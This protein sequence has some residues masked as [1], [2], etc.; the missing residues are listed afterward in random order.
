MSTP[1]KDAAA[2]R[3]AIALSRKGFPTPNPHVGCVI[4]GQDGS[5]V[6]DGWCD[7]AGAPHAEAMALDEAGTRA[8]GGTAYVTLEPCN[9]FGRTPPCSQA[10][11]RAGVRRVVIAALDP[12]PVA[13]GGA[14][15]LREAG[16]EV[17][18]GLLAESAAEVNHQ[19]LFAMAN[20]RP[21]FTLKAAVGLDGRIALPNGE[22]KWI[23]GPTARKAGHALRA[24]CGAVL[25]GCRTVSADN[26]ELTARVPGVTNPPV[27]IVLDPNRRLTGKERV[28]DRQAETWHIT[29][30]IDL[31]ALAADWYRRGITGVLVEGGAITHGHILRAGLADRI[32]LFVAPKVLGSGPSWIQADGLPHPL[33]LGWEI[34][35]SSRRGED[36]QVSLRKRFA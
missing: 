2:M 19:F 26:P 5:A 27:R 15:A 11:I 3:R 30:P 23:T 25:V 32:E 35:K 31:P 28:F 24:E 4:T 17:E 12:N 16:I 29:G 20:A 1:S 18:V 21:E 34:I 14:K 7:Y 36:I 22:S 10:L 9:H 8:E 13:A 33:E 6:G